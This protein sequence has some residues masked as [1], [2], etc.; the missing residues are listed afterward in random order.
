M[1]TMLMNTKTKIIT[2][3]NKVKIRVKL[4]LRIVNIYN[5]KNPIRFSALANSK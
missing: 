3:E 2:Q 4:Y 1:I 5:R